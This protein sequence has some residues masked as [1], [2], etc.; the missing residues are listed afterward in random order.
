MI[1]E[2]M[3]YSSV[4]LNYAKLFLLLVINI[5]YLFRHI[6]YKWCILFLFKKIKYGNISIVERNAILKPD[7][8]LEQVDKEILNVV[9]NLKDPSVILYVTNEKFYENFLFYGER[10]LNQSFEIDFQT[11]NLYELFEIIYAPPTQEWTFFKKFVNVTYKKQ[12]TIETNEMKTIMYKNED[13]IFHADEETISN[14][15]SMQEIKVVIHNGNFDFKNTSM[16]LNILTDSEISKNILYKRLERVSPTDFS[17]ENYH[18]TFLK[19]L[20][21]KNYLTYNYYFCEK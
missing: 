14:L 15:P 7:Y 19:F 8:T 10:G 12:A 13:F 21:Q 3:L 1:C 20:F 9:N 17:N 16:E 11:E 5:L 2:I 4:S 6:I 18:T